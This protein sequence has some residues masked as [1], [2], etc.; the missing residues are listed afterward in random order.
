MD[1]ARK[2]LAAVVN[3]AEFAGE[4]A[5]LTRRGHRVAA[6]VPVALL[7]ELEALEA[8]EDE[9]D[10]AAAQAAL[11]ERGEPVPWSSLRAELGI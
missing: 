4:R 9:A 6:V 10:L 8:A 1:D 2:K 7:E 11:A 5:Y 3:R